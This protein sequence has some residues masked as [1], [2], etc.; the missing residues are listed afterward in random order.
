MYERQRVWRACQAC[1]RK[2]VK[3]DGEHPCQSCTRNKAECV[4]E[5]Y[6]NMRLVDPQYVIKLEK[7]LA[8]MERNLKAQS[9]AQSGIG[10]TETLVHPFTSTYDEDSHPHKAAHQSVPASDEGVVSDPP[11][12]L[13]AC[14]TD[15]TV[16]RPANSSRPETITGPLN[17]QLQPEV[18]DCEYYVVQPN[19]AEDAPIGTVSIP[20]D[21]TRLEAS[22]THV[23][24]DLFYHFIYPIFPIIHSYNFRP[25]YAR[26]LCGQ[27][28]GGSNH[29]DDNQFSFL[30]YALLAAAAS[31]IPKEHP[32]FDQEECRIYKGAELGNLLYLHALSLSS[33][34]AYQ[35]NTTSAINTVA[36]HGIMSLYLTESG[37]V[38]DAWVTTGHAMRLYQGLDVEDDGDG[39]GDTTTA[40]AADTFSTRSNIWRCLYILDRSLSTALLKPLAMDDVES[41]TESF[42]GE[43]DQASALEAK[44]DPWFSVVAAFHVTMGRIY[45]SVRQIR[46]SQS[47]QNP[48]LRDTLRSY[49]KKHD[50]ELE[51]YYTKQVLPRIETADRQVES[52][53]LQTIAV[54]SY[55]IG[56][57]LLYRTF[58]ERLNIAEPEAFLRCAE[59]ASNCIKVTPEVIAK[60]PASHFVIQQSRAIYAS[61]KVLLH[62]MRLARN[63]TFT[64]K[65]WSDVETGFNMLRDFKI[66]WPEINKYQSLIEKDMELTQIDLS[67]HDILNRTFDQYGQLATSQQ[68]RS[69][70]TMGVSYNGN[71]TD[72]INIEKSIGSH[73]RK[74]KKRSFCTDERMQSDSVVPACESR[75]K[76]G[77]P[78]PNAIVPP[79][80]LDSNMLG[81]LNESEPLDSYYM[82]E[83]SAIDDDLLLGDLI[84]QP[85]TL[86]DPSLDLFNDAML[87]GSI[88][89]F[90]SQYAD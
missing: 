30:L 40:D 25:Q 24:V 83:Q 33:D 52:I 67:K 53:A 46:K 86:G 28:I 10:E 5:P 48:R 7:R 60:V 54:S 65:A 36:A 62:C 82:A 14:S 38:N 61:T 1:R 39:D 88:D 56:V 43:N 37:R 66:Q 49:V 70:E 89:S 41:D 76:R 68:S 34:R 63:P 4:F 45:R 17:L 84:S 71:S 13:Q 19:D 69:S 74:G 47:S 8:Q 11:D 51:K 26:W 16:E 59:A 85:S 22:L 12:F 50:A 90:F 57:V 31:V 6:N 2:K 87:M 42:D 80:Q 64:N 78:V 58:I 18:D 23:L 3:C 27:D 79:S 9:T 81:I 73:H 15:A 44:T 32:I 72:R 29:N 75:P 21:I 77:K 35:R 20:I 55:Y